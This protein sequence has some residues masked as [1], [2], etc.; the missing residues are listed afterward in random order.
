MAVLAVCMA[1]LP[2][3]CGGTVLTAGPAWQELLLLCLVAY[4]VIFCRRCIENSSENAACSFMCNLCTPTFS[5]VLGVQN[6]V[7]IMQVI[8][9]LCSGM[10]VSS[11]RLLFC[12]FKLPHVFLLTVSTFPDHFRSGRLIKTFLWAGPR[13]VKI[14]NLG[15]AVSL[16]LIRL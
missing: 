2:W 3:K 5:Q 10:A 13:S 7:K 4:A 11:G 12:Q 9:T 15:I 6:I 14:T 1:Y 8:M 16:E